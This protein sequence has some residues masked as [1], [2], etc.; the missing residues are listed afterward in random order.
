MAHVAADYQWLVKEDVF[1]LLRSDGVPI[2]VLLSVTLVPVETGA[3]LDGVVPCHALS[4]R[5]S[6]TAGRR[7][8]Q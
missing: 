2:P 4:I 1:R 3:P 8:I 6:Y 5:L 7:R